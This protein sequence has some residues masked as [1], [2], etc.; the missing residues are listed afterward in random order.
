MKLHA[1]SHCFVPDLG[2][3]VQLG[4]FQLNVERAISRVLSGWPVS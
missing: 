2:M 4:A 3:V 1:Q